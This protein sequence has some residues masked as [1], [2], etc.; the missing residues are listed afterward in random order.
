MYKNT[1]QINVKFTIF[2]IHKNHLDMAA[3]ENRFNTFIR[4]NIVVDSKLLSLDIRW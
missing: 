3:L 2:D 1:L 4:V